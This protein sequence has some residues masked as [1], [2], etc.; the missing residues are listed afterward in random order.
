MRLYATFQGDCPGRGR[1]G[2][3]SGVLHDANNN[4]DPLERLFAGSTYT[5]GGV[6][7]YKT[8]IATAI[9]AFTDREHPDIG[10]KGLKVVPDLLSPQDGIT[11]EDVSKHWVA[12]RHGALVY[13]QCHYFHSI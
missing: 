8:S 7:R 12:E 1:L 5:F 10:G 2:F 13:G 6:Q 9:Q 4:V 3:Q 11:W